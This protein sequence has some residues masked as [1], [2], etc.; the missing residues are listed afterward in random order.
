V[1]HPKKSVAPDNSTETSARHQTVWKASVRAAVP[2]GFLAEWI[3]TVILLL[4]GTTTL[5]QA[6]VIPTGSMEDTLLVG[7][8][9]LVDKLAFAPSGPVSRNLL[10]YQDVHRGDIIV[11]R[12]PI[13]IKQTFVKRVM[14]VAGDRIHLENKRVF[15]NGHP[16]VE[17]YVVHKTD[18]V[19]SYRDN[20]PTDPDAPLFPQARAMLEHNVVNGNVVVPSGHYFAMGDNRDESL[21]SRYFGFVPRQNIIGKPLVIYWS[22]D[23]TTDELS[24]PAPSVSH[25]FDIATHF[26]SK[27]RWN[28]TLRFIH[29]YPVQ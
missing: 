4:F 29:P 24:T 6:F 2:R 19:G 27:T 16:L 26:V 28:R 11:F 15:L 9:L 10:P 22:Y 23:A 20:F 7:D 1:D 18:Y 13:D 25:L 17:P 14:G 8:H 5:V 21:D 3:V 12:Y